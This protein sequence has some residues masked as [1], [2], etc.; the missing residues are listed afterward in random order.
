MKFFAL[1]GPHASGKTSIINRLMRE[2]AVQHIGLEIGKQFYYERT[3]NGFN[4][5]N[6]DENF[7]MEVSHAELMREISMFNNAG[8]S[9][10]ETWHPGNLAYVLTRNADYYDKIFEYIY[11]NSQLIQF[12]CTKIIALTISIETIKKRTITFKNNVD[13]A[14]DFYTKIAQNL[15]KPLQDLKLYEKTVFIDANGPFDSVYEKVYNEIQ[16]GV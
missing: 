12:S 16:I 7:E 14:A 13:W 5:S 11:Q 8:T 4:T 1:I 9:I 2:N 3:K 6:A 10:V 15:L